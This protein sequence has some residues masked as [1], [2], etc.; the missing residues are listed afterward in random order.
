[1]PIVTPSIPI[2]GDLIGLY[3]G[4]DQQGSVPIVSEALQLPS[5]VTLNGEATKTKKNGY[6]F[7]FHT[8]SEC[9]ILMNR[10]L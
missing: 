5:L 3:I 1:M 4:I 6:T 9:N 7:D 10:Q 2:A 8:I